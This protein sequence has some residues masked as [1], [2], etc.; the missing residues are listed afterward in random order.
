MKKIMRSLQ[1]FLN[2]LLKD[3]LIKNSQ[4]FYDFLSIEKDEDFEKKKKI[5]N[6]LRTPI[7][8]KDIKSLEGK[9]KIEVTPQNEILLDKIRDNSILNESILKQK[10]SNLKKSL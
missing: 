4:I 1:N 2:Y 8:F 7:E 5:Y 9:L 3:D 10:K 6:K